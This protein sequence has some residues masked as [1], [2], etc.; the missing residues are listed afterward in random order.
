MLEGEL[1]VLW[2]VWSSQLK[3]LGICGS[4][5]AGEK[6]LQEKRVFPVIDWDMEM[7][8]VETTSRRWL[9][10]KPYSGWGDK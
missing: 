4:R 2:V 7:S 5:S 9:V 3:S 8:K 10:H 1:A 6:L